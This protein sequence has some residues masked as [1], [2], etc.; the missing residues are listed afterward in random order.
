MVNYINEH[1]KSRSLPSR[2]A[3]IEIIFQMNNPDLLL[4]LP[5]RGAWIEI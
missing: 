4:S 3:W 1:I 2:G 5:S